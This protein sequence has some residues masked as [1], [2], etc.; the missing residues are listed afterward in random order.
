LI[1]KQSFKFLNTLGF[2]LK[3]KV[4]LFTRES[5]QIARSVIAFNPIQMMNYP[6]F[7][8]WFAM[9]L[10]PDKD[11][12]QDEPSSCCSRMVGQINRSIASAILIFVA[13]AKFISLLACFLM[14]YS[15]FTYCPAVFYSTTFAPFGCHIKSHPLP[16]GIYRFITVNTVMR[17]RYY[18]TSIFTILAPLSLGAAGFAAIN[19][20][21]SVFFLPSP[22]LLLRPHRFILT[23][24]YLN[25][26]CFKGC[27]K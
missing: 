16:F 5:H 2:S 7:R 10:L 17:N 13:L 4:M 25:A 24:C 20:N 14:C 23:Y 19:T 1:I 12:L 3:D 6:A 26:N 27:G 22:T 8:Q 18:P 9:N 11:M 21:R 15:Q